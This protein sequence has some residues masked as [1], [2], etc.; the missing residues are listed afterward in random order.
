[1]PPTLGGERLGGSRYI[2]RMPARVPLFPLDVVLFPGE[3]LPLHIFEPRYRRMLADCLEGDQRFGLTTASPPGPGSIGCMA[4]IRAA[5]PLSDGRSNIVVLGERRFGVRAVLEAD[6]PYLMAAIEEFGDREGTA[7]LPGELADLR[8]LGE[9][10][11]ETLAVLADRPGEGPEWAADPE[12]LSFQV[13]ALTEAD[14]DSRL[15]LL[16]ERSTRERTRSLVARLPQ[17][18]TSVRSRADVHVRARFNGKGHP[19]SDIVTG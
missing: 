17:L 8:R 5:E 3:L 1:V 7:P 14:R 11:R 13:A 18:V 2:P 19:G 9:E 12:L 15:D 16:A 6:T 10:L 4:R